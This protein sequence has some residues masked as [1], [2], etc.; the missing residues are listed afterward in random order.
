M[1]RGLAL[2]AS[3]LSGLACATPPP[4]QAPAHISLE[5][6]R[7]LAPDDGAAAGAPVAVIVDVTASMGEAASAGATLDVAARRGAARLVENL[8]SARPVWL[9]ALGSGDAAECQPLYRVDRAV[10]GGSRAGLLEGL[11]ALPTRGE[12]SLPA[13]LDGVRAELERDGAPSGSRV[14]VF[15]D[16][17]DE[18][19][20][21]RDLC[22]AASRLAAAGLRLH[23]VAIGPRTA[24][25]CLREP[26]ALAEPTLPAVG[27]PGPV[28]FRVV[29]GGAEPAVVGCSE[30]GGLPVAAPPGDIRVTVALDPPLEVEREVAAGGRHVLQVLD[31]PGL[32]PPVRKWRWMDTTPPESAP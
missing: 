12:G 2:A 26:G 23:V 19:T 1:R 20:D 31:F 13:A 18:C 28:A 22:G 6:L 15:S 8:P 4:A 14:V 7:G 9:Y 32:D 11:R 30:S 3:A 17:G 5:L 29:S 16:L 24:P 21:D 27:A 10:A 25:A